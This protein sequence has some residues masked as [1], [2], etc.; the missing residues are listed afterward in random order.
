MEILRQVAG[1][2]LQVKGLGV[3]SS[4]SVPLAPQPARLSKAI[5]AAIETMRNT[6]VFSLKMVLPWG[7]K[8]G[9]SG[10]RFPA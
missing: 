9:L 2:P 3:L 1:V 7:Q 5:A 8:G 6:V 10:S 4:S